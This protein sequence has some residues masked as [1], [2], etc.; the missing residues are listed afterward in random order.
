VPHRAPTAGCSD[1]EPVRATSQRGRVKH[2]KISRNHEKW[3]W[4]TM[5]M[6]NQVIREAWCAKDEETR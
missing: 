1:P 5:V 3:R 4:E 2:I 6:G